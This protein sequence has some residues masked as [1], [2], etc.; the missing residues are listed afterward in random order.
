MASITEHDLMQGIGDHIL[1]VIGMKIG[2]HVTIH[3]I[4][5]DLLEIM[6]MILGD[7]NDRGWTAQWTAIL[8]AAQLKQQLVPRLLVTVPSGDQAGQTI[9]EQPK[10]A[11]VLLKHF[12][13]IGFVVGID[14][15]IQTG[16]PNDHGA[17]IDQLVVQ[18]IEQ[19]DGFQAGNLTTGFRRIGTECSR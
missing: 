12:N 4:E 5:S 8:L 11:V 13:S 9:G 15:R 1:V 17:I 19:Y 3:G 2:S 14:R 6:A 16:L 10:A 7:D 18:I